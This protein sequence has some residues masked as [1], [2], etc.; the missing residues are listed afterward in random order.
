MIL[1][2]LKQHFVFTCCTGQFN[3]KTEDS[4][5]NKKLE[6]S[7]DTFF[8]ILETDLDLTLKKWFLI[9]E[10]LLYLLFFTKS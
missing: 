9:C 6:H 1:D 7:L 5:S 8:I 4:S 10:T 2:G 3:P